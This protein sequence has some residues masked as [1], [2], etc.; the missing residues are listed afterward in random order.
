M[1]ICKILKIRLRENRDNLTDET[2]QEASPGTFDGVA[3]DSLIQF[4]ENADRCMME[5][6]ENY[7][8]FNED[9]FT[10]D[11]KNHKEKKWKV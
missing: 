10:H 8:Q 3:L 2:I 11:V 1:L 5:W 6:M 4:L 7:N 9:T